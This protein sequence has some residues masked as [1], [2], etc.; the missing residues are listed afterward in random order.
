MENRKE[1][2]FTGKTSEGISIGATRQEIE[3]AYG[4]PSNQAEL[5]AR[6]DLSPSLYYKPLQ[7]IFNLQDGRL[8]ELSFDKP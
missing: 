6:G 1:V 2:S 7:T 4:P 8:W 3:R 5:A